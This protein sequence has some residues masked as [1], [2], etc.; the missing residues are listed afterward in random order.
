MKARAVIAGM[1]RVD[2]A[3]Y[4]GWAGDCPGCDKDL[5]KAVA[6]VSRL[7]KFDRVTALQNAQATWPAFAAA[8]M[9]SARD[10]AAGDLLVIFRSGHG[11]RV[12]D[13]DGDELDG[14]D[15]TLCMFDRQVPDDEMWALLCNAIP[16]GVRVA[17]ITDAC[18]S[19]TAFRDGP[20]IGI[21]KDQSQFRGRL[22]ALSGCA[23]DKVSWGGAS[24]GRF[25]SALDRCVSDGLTWRGWFAAAVRQLGLGQVPK[26]TEVG[27]SFADQ[28]AL[29]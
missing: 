5:D 14:Y 7:R 29:T 17:I 18:H 13:I 4:G 11:G 3:G 27:E 24:G 26:M 25:T 2:P 23:D 15:E 12:V 1:T 21:A 19:E 22:L 10:L 6:W 9:D 20:P 8:I 16:A 28:P